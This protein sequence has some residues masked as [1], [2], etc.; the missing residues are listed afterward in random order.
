MK[1][2]LSILLAILIAMSFAACSVPEDDPT[3]TNGLTEPTVIDDQK[4]FKHEATIAETVLLDKD[5]IRITATDLV[6]GSYAAELH[7][8]FENNTGKDLTFVSNS[9][10]Y[11]CNSVNGY[12]VA[13]GYICSVCQKV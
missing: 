8:T 10:G 3:G 7:L 6:Y 12:M 11:S 13:D 4:E 5:G 2:V 1:K 9:I